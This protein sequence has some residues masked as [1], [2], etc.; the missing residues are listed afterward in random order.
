MAVLETYEKQPNDDKD[1]DIDYLEWLPEG[2]TLLSATYV[3]TCLTDGSPYD[4]LVNHVDVSSS[5]IKVW[6][7][8]GVDG[9]KYKVTILAETANAVPRPRKDECE[10]I[11][12]VK[13]T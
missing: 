6:V 2:D 4:L 12:I 13:D 11:F 3:V 8:G 1:Y 7:S 5:R 9:Q 10:L